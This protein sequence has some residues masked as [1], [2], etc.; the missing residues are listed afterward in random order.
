MIDEWPSLL[1]WVTFPMYE[2]IIFQQNRR[3]SFVPD[4]P[5]V[6]VTNDDRMVNG[7]L[8]RV[9]KQILGL[10]TFFLQKWRSGM[11]FLSGPME[12]PL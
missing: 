10:L 5:V 8:L 3:S 1:L 11:I 2:G 7:K 12:Y 6:Q 9:D 4:G